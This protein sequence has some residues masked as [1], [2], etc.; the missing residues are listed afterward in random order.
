MLKRGFGIPELRD[1]PWFGITKPRLLNFASLGEDHGLVTPGEDLELVTPGED[2]GFVTPD[3]NIDPV[4]PGEDP[5]SRA[6]A[7]H[8]SRIK[9]GM[10]VRDRFRND[11][12]RASPA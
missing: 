3:A 8:G 10:T 5:G 11:G 6:L 7:I 9:S 12:L 4:T 1:C 2:H